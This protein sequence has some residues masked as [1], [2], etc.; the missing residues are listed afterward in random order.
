MVNITIIK[1]DARLDE[2]RPF[3]IMKTADLTPLLAHSFNG[4]YENKV[5]DYPVNKDAEFVRSAIEKTKYPLV[6]IY[7]D[8]KVPF[9]KSEFKT[10]NK[11]TIIDGEITEKAG[12]FPILDMVL[13]ERDR[14]KVF[15]TLKSNQSLHHIIFLYLYDNVA[16]YPN[17]IGILSF[18]DMVALHKDSQRFCE[19]LAFAFQPVYRKMFLRYHRPKKE[20]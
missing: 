11:V 9:K 10:K 3:T 19:L 5:M 20:E 1:G 14:S 4:K 8:G 7:A 13:N 2:F 6:I 16:Q 18:I 12:L 17:N 15:S